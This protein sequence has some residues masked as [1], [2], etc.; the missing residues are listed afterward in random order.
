MALAF[1]C[2]ILLAIAIGLL[3]GVLEYTMGA[4]IWLVGI[5]IMA[6][7][8]AY[9]VV[10]ILHWVPPLRRVRFA[11]D[12]VHRSLP[13][14]L[15]VLRSDSALHRSHWRGARRPGARRAWLRLRAGQAARFLLLPAAAIGIVVYALETQLATRGLILLGVAVLT[16]PS[17]IGRLGRVNA[18]SRQEWHRLR[19]AG[20]DEARARDVRAPIL[21]LRSFRND[22]GGIEALLGAAT[23]PRTFEQVLVEPLGVHGP[24]IAIGQPAEPLPH[25]GAHREYVAEDW[26]RRVLARLAEA[27]IIVVVL[28]ETPG[29]LWEIEQI[30]ALRL[31]ERTILVQ[32]EAEHRVAVRRW[33]AARAAIRR[34]RPDLRARMRLGLARSLAIVFDAGASPRAIR[35]RNAAAEYYRDAIVLAAWWVMRFAARRG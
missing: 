29:L 20:A 4:V 12:A 32:R 5:S 14:R 6:G 3:F 10:F 21:V 27:A 16:V 7:W 28:D 35:G 17:G 23:G 11:D 1:G 18:R 26:Q 19:I 2:F 8:I 22:G 34:A 9:V 31:H 13:W 15:R 33:R 25:L 24:V 30:F